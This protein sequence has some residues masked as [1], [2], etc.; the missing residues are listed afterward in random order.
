MKKLA[1]LFL[2]TFVGTNLAFA[3]ESYDK[4]YSKLCEEVGGKYVE[5]ESY[6]VQKKCNIWEYLMNLDSFQDKY[7]H[8]ILWMMINYISE[9]KYSSKSEWKSYLEF[10]AHDID[11]TRAFLNAD[12]NSE[13]KAKVQEELEV[14]EWIYNFMF[15]QEAL[16]E[17]IISQIE[18]ILEKYEAKISENKRQEF[19]KLFATKL[20]EKVKEME[21]FQMVASFT[22]EWYKAFL[23]KMN[24]YK[25]M[26]ILVNGRIL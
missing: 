14:Q 2:L 13:Q 12:L 10:L 11:D 24:V 15:L 17:K 16:W 7:N 5:L 23:F 1:I 21:Y 9:Y 8:F 26:L 20:D 18:K 6:P 25:Y 22:P 19:Y 4:D 3:W